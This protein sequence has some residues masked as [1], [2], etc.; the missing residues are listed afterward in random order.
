MKIP[1]FPLSKRS[2]ST[3][4]AK[5][6]PP[7]A[8]APVP[9]PAPAAP[10]QPKSASARPTLALNSKG[11]QSGT[12]FLAVDPNDELYIP[13]ERP[14]TQPSMPA[15]VSSTSKFPPASQVKSTPATPPNTFLAFDPSDEP[16]VPK[17]TEEPKNNNPLEIN[18][19]LGAD[20]DTPPP[21]PKAQFD[22]SAF[23]SG[24]PGSKTKTGD[25]QAP[26]PDAVTPAETPSPKPEE[27]PATPA[28]KQ[29]APVDDKP[30]EKPV[31]LP[32]P[33]FDFETPPHPPTSAKSGELDSAKQELQEALQNNFDLLQEMSSLKDERELMRAK[34]IQLEQQQ[35]YAPTIDP[36]LADLTAKNQSLIERIAGLESVI[37]DSN[38]LSEEIAS[39]KQNVEKLEQEKSQLLTQSGPN[40]EQIDSEKASLTAKITSLEQEKSALEQIQTENA[41]L[42]ASIASLK[43]E[44]AQLQQKLTALEASSAAPAVDSELNN[45]LAASEG[46]NGELVSENA[47]LK[48]QLD[49]LTQ[50]SQE[51][52]GV[53]ESLRSEISGLETKI[54]SLKDQ[55]TLAGT[56]SSDLAGKNEELLAKVNE[57]TAQNTELS[58][59]A[60]RF[61]QEAEMSRAE[62]SS[63]TAKVTEFTEQVSV[64]K[65][66]T[67]E[68]KEQRTSI[69]ARADHLV[70]QNAELRDQAA[71]L[72]NELTTSKDQISALTE[73]LSKAPTAAVAEGGLDPA[74][75]LI[76]NN[77][78]AGVS[79]I[80][81][82]MNSEGVMLWATESY[83]R[84]LG[85]SRN[86]E[87]NAFLTDIHEE[88]QPAFQDAVNRAFAGEQINLTCRIQKKD[89]TWIELEVDFTPITSTETQEVD[90][91]L[92]EAV[93]LTD[94]KALDQ[95]IISAQ[96]S[97]VSAEAAQKI[98]N[99]FQALLAQLLEHV[100]VIRRL[101]TAQPVVITRLQDMERA[102][103]KSR[104]TL[105]VITATIPVEPT[106]SMARRSTNLEPF[107]NE[108][109]IPMIRGSSWKTHFA[110][111]KELP[112][113]NIDPEA[114]GNAVKCIVTNSLQSGSSGIIQFTAE[115]IPADKF[116]AVGN[117]EPGNYVLVTIADNGPGIPHKIKSHIFER[118]FST[119]PG[120]R[121]LGLNDARTLVEKLGG[122][123]NLASTPGIGTTVMI[124]LPYRHDLR[125]SNDEAA[126]T[127]NRKL[128]VLLMDD[129]PMILDIL[130]RMLV[131]LGYQ[132]TTT[133]DGSQ[134]IAA[135]AKAK[136]TNVPFDIILMDLIIP[137]GLGGADALPTINKINPNA[138]IIASSGHLDHPAMR[139]F[140]KF[141]FT[142]V[143]Q[144]P[145]KLERLQTL[146]AELYTSAPA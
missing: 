43:D 29:T 69:Q 36:E 12:S 93:D 61:H 119:K 41:S 40:A 17:K 32:L 123:L 52:S 141:G 57:L 145:Y 100:T 10:A 138:K 27:A 102:L 49:A 9:T 64:F 84:I 53:V 118:H 133:T 54:E 99:D 2:S 86:P 106:V 18:P 87:S 79:N 108:V 46:K 143:L 55:I 95:A 127:I 45:R 50:H 112:E 94:E 47:A 134:A 15:S 121:G 23:Y 115:D 103:N 31:E 22:L 126:P 132:V 51:N 137:S 136:A 24:K 92:V 110:L 71:Y 59:E 63:L 21:K 66:A 6:T 78:Q 85:Y 81:V 8:A 34:V 67:A 37:A 98:Q 111:P 77:L 56:F 107:L 74:L 42:T 105:D 135:A 83:T 35:A 68:L 125:D 5:P 33:K 88:D 7:P 62:I 30:V 120:A 72:R 39:L 130:S 25:L 89:T 73:Q 116:E 14:T 65:V 114:L 19:N 26:A 128:R 146:L 1:F 11:S 76:L 75:G 144:K 4:D 104:E 142:A 13:P 140:K 44:N 38:A 139:E 113:V 80:M 16:Y 124:Y 101:A 131:N 82:V 117:L 58:L 28:L 109:T 3:A 91:L 60:K 122:H 90:R 96:T 70:N 97:R 20:L 48:S 129:E